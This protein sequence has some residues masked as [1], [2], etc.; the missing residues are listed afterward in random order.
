MCMLTI[1]EMANDIFVHRR[2]MGDVK[3][4]NHNK[5]PKTSS[6]SNINKFC[7]HFQSLDLKLNNL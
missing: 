7:F 2:K 4:R 6:T 5:C 3:L 1:P